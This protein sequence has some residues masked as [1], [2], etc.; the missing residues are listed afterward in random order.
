M[1]AFLLS[2]SIEPLLL[3]V[4]LGLV[5]TLILGLGVGCLI[6]RVGNAIPLPPPNPHDQESTATWT[7]LVGQSTGGS[8]IGHF[9]RPL[10]FAACW[11]HAWLLITGWLVFKAAF[12]WQGA[13]FTAFP[14]T[15]PD[16]TQLRWV[17]VKRQLGTHHVATALVGTAA[18]IVVALVGVAVGKWIKLQ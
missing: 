2:F 1:K 8:W 14:R 17:A 3:Q 13:N 16:A 15:M 11:L 10:F 4:A 18:N 6:K 5:V 7:Q 12:Y 9:E